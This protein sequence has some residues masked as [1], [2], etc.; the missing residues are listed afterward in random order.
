MLNFRKV[1][2]AAMAG[3]GFFIGVSQAAAQQRGC[4]ASE[5]RRSFS[6][7][8]RSGASDIT[9]SS[10]PITAAITGS[11]SAGVG[12]FAGWN[13]TRRSLGQRGNTYFDFTGNNVT[14][15]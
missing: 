8:L 9:Q 4:S 7:M 10:P 1:R 15:G 13:S 2:C 11:R 12:G 5:P 6:A 14:V 3:A